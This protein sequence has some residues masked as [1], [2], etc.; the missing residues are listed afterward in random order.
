MNAAN[1]IQALSA[2]VKEAGKYEVM[3]TESGQPYKIEYRKF[4][5]FVTKVMR[6]RGAEAGPYLRDDTPVP[7][8]YLE[9]LRDDFGAKGKGIP[10]KID[11]EERRRRMPSIQDLWDKLVK[12]VRKHGERNADGAEMAAN[13][14]EGTSGADWISAVSGDVGQSVEYALSG[15]KAGRLYDAFFEVL[16]SGEYNRPAYSY[17][18][19]DVQERQDSLKEIY[20]SAWYTG[21]IRSM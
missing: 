6:L 16:R 4:I 17:D 14:P 5:Q 7:D 21:A 9:T 20:S 12:E 8:R 3:T 19:W 1:R 18:S 15:T 13:A 11:Y 10:D 2:S